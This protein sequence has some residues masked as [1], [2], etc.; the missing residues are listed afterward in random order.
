MIC[1]A[2]L[3]LHR[4]VLLGFSFSSSGLRSYVMRMCLQTMTIIWPGQKRWRCKIQL[5]LICVSKWWNLKMPQLCV[6]Y[7][8]QKWMLEVWNGIYS[9][10]RTLFWQKKLFDTS[11]DCIQTGSACK[12]CIFYGVT[13]RRSKYIRR[14]APKNI[15]WLDSNN[16]PKHAFWVS[17]SLYQNLDLKICKNAFLKAFYHFSSRKLI[18]FSLRTNLKS[19]GQYLK[20][21]HQK[22]RV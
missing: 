12:K 19:M 21:N 1:D 17:S 14:I 13:S 16:I 11:P 9:L 22:S 10:E 3:V 8:R 4:I 6:K 18:F 15:F 2:S 20:G 7:S 5:F